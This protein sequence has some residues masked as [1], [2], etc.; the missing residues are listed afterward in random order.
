VDLD[1]DGDLDILIAGH[2]SNNLVWFENPT[3]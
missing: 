3:K 2:V 1:R